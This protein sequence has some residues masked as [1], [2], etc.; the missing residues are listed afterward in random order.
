MQKKFNR[1]FPFKNEFP[2]LISAVTVLVI[3]WKILSF[4]DR[5]S[6][7]WSLPLLAF[8]TGFATILLPKIAAKFKKCYAIMASGIALLLIDLF[9][10]LFPKDFKF[11]GILGIILVVGLITDF[12]VSLRVSIGDILFDLAVSAAGTAIISFFNITILSIVMLIL[13]YFVI[14]SFRFSF[15]YP[16]KKD[17]SE[18]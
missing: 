13:I 2:I 9:S 18:R 16:T 4:F 15:K 11:F 17:D 1:E 12:L 10:R 3:S 7:W 5:I 14:L 6:Q 8:L